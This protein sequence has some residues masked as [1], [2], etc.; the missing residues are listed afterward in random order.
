[1]FTHNT[2]DSSGVK[3]EDKAWGIYTW[4]VECITHKHRWG[5][6]WLAC[7]TAGIQIIVMFLTFTMFSF[8]PTGML[9]FWQRISHMLAVSQQT[10]CRSLHGFLVLTVPFS[11]LECSVVRASSNSKSLPMLLALA[12][13][14]SWGVWT[15]SQVDYRLNKFYDTI[16][17]FTHVPTTQPCWLSMV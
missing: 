15:I 14:W 12:D 6:V 16:E 10:S 2:W 11:R 8:L 13:Y 4:T 3:P 1:M 17:I 9:R 7:T 5:V